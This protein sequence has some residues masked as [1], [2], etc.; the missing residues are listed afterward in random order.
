MFLPF[1]IDAVGY[2]PD[3]PKLLKWASG[4]VG[5]YNCSLMILLHIVYHRQ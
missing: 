4:Y 5:L 3:T 2:D 1:K